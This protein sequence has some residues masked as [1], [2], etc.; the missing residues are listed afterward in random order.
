MA[1]PP[2]PQGD[3]KTTTP[4]TTSAETRQLH[5]PVCNTGFV[6]NRR[7]AYCCDRCRKTAWKRRPQSAVNVEPVPPARRRRDVTVYFC[8]SCD[9]RY[10]GE[11]WCSDCQQPCTRI[12]TG[13]LCP[14]CLL[15]EPVTITDL[16][17]QHP[18]TET[19]AIPLPKR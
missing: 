5:C 7:Q 4:V 17:G 6:R 12:G 8:P 16:T 15:T 9:T 2:R 13:G 19:E 3:D 10:F 1:N 18:D 14:H 11:Q